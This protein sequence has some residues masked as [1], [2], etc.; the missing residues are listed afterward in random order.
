MQVNASAHYPVS[1]GRTHRFS[2][3]RSFEQKLDTYC[4]GVP[5]DAQ[6]AGKLGDFSVSRDRTDRWP[7]E[8]PARSYLWNDY[9]LWSKW[10]KAGRIIFDFAPALLQ[11]LHHTDFSYGGDGFGVPFDF[12][13]L[14]LASLKIPFVM[15]QPGH[16][17]GVYVQVLPLDTPDEDVDPNETDAAEIEKMRLCP[18]DLRVRLDFT[19]DYLPHHEAHLSTYLRDGNRGIHLDL[20]QLAMVGELDEQLHD[21][22]L[23]RRMRKRSFSDLVHPDVSAEQRDW[24]LERH[25]DFV[26]RASEVVMNCLLYLTLAERE[27]QRQLP[28]DLPDYLRQRLRRAGTKRKREVVEQDARA[29]GFSHVH[30]VGRSFEESSLPGAGDG[31]NSVP[32]WRRGHWRRQPV[33]PARTE[34]KLLWIKPTIVNKAIGEPRQGRVYNV[35]P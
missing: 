20:V 9:E 13:Y 7:H 31:S 12:F 33:G 32:H 23:A 14:S 27:V 15:G 28:A 35:T 18:V 19:G 29:A 3:T 21:A 4:L 24:I 22:A 2:R 30:F 26:E 5:L 8:Q 16:V 34:R 6:D 25:A 10:D 17:S 1:V 11:Q